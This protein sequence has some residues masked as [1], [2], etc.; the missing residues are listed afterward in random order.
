VV[1]ILYLTGNLVCRIK[2]RSKVK[3]NFKGEKLLSVL[4]VDDLIGENCEILFILESPHK[5]ELKKRFPVA[6][7]SGV[8]L[9]KSVFKKDKYREIPFGKMLNKPYKYPEIAD[10]LNKF[11]VMN[12]SQLPLQINSIESKN[13]L[14]ELEEIYSEFKIIRENP[15][16]ISRNSNITASLEAAIESDFFNRL[17][18]IIEDNSLKKIVPLGA[19]AHSFY[20]KYLFNSDIFSVYGFNHPSR[21]RI[22]ELKCLM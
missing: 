3:L 6:G 1:I 22:E 10:R 17:D 16:S 21:G 11:A 15:F 18:S 4:M 8:N 20:S 14:E 9:S 2:N 7:E 19:F 12:V 5:N 13:L